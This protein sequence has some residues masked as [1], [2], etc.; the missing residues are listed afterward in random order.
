[1]G[2][3]C[4]PVTGSP[5]GS[6]AGGARGGR[7]SEK[8]PESHPGAGAWIPGPEALGSLPLLLQK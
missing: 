6:D 5:G 2:P 3:R 1:M 8:L 7:Y 4:P